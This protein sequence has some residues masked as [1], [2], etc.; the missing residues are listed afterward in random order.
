MTHV[1]D[2]RIHGTTKQQ[3]APIFSESKSRFCSP[4][5]PPCSPALKK[6]VAASIVI[7]TSR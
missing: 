2:R 7:A 1:A 5:R 6:R 3:V 4:Y